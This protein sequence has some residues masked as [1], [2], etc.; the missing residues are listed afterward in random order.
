EWGYQTVAF[1]TGYV[2]S[3]I[4]NADLFLT[5]EKAPGPALGAWRPFGPLNPF[6]SLLLRHPY[7]PVVDALNAAGVLNLPTENLDT[8]LQAD[9][10]QQHYARIQFALSALE[11]I[12]DLPGPKFVYAHIV[13]PHPPLVLDREGNFAHT[14][15][16][17]KTGYTDAITY[18]NTRMGPIL[19]GILAHSAVPPI[20]ILEGDHGAKAVEWTPDVM[21]NLSAY[22]FP[23]GGNERL[24]NTITPVNL[25]RIIF[26]EYFGTNYG[27]LEDVSY[28]SLTDDHQLDMERVP[29]TCGR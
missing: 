4:R 2:W 11:T 7:R 8:A 28:R 18:L 9:V 3:E 6:E 14:P 19:R 27:T 26:D 1:P 29:N 24:Y 17:S 16:A 22:Y 5:P 13:S 20:I 12:P 15:D 10:Y 23:N 25:F 21:K